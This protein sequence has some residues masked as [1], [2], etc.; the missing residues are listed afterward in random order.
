MNF[1][2]LRIFYE[3]AM[4]LNMTKVGK[5]LYI[6]QPSVSQA[7]QELEA[8]LDVKLFDRIGKKIKLTNEG[9]VYLNYVR[10]ILNIYEEGVDKIKSIRESRSGEIKIGA[11][12]T[13]GIYVLPKIIK[14]FHNKYNDIK[15]SLII[16]NTENIENLILKNE[17][18]FAFVEGNVHSDEI[19]VEKFW[20]DNLVFICENKS[21][22]ET[23]EDGKKLSIIMR[24]KGS[25]TREIIEN[26]LIKE[27][28]PFD[29][30]MELGSTEAIKRSVE[31]GMGIGCVSERCIKRELKYGILK[32]ISVKG[33]DIRRDLLFICHRDKFINNNMSIF[34][35]EAKLYK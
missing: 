6:S 16:D 25:G 13:I 21:N 30:F 8:E 10:R 35:K 28:I 17:I 2:K 19:N 23:I 11:S 31:S 24:E 7:I 26:K 15:I 9:E 3:T 32:K 20:E 12:T 1:R 34:I 5:K 27:N 29:I 18:D 22:I 33:I 4:E 14:K